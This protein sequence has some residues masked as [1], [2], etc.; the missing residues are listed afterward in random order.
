MDEIAYDVTMQTFEN[1]PRG[2]RRDP[3]AVGEAVRR[4]VRSA[5]SEQW[6]KK[7]VCVV[8]VLEV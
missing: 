3:D 7:T 8:H 1:L 2:K 5:I 6:G 4:A